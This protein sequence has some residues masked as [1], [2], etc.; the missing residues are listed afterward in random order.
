MSN[1]NLL[2]PLIPKGNPI[3]GSK[4]NSS[5]QQHDPDHNYL[6]RNKESFRKGKWTVMKYPGLLLPLISIIYLYE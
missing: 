6:S 2:P 4:V 1:Y 3:S 5:V